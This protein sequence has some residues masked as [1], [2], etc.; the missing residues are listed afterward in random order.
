MIGAAVYQ[1]FIPWD[2]DIDLMMTREEYDRFLE[3][4]PQNCSPRYHLLHYSTGDVTK[5]PAL[6]ARVEDLWT[7][8]EEE[9]ARRVRQGR[10]FVDITVF[11]EVP[12]R[13]RLRLLRLY[14]GYTC[15]FLYRM[16]GMIPGT[17]WKRMLMGLLPGKV[18]EK[19]LRERYLRFEKTCRNAGKDCRLCAELLSAAYGDI[20]YDRRIFEAYTDILFE[21]EKLMIV[22]KYR[23]Y[24]FMRYHRTDFPKELPEERRQKSHILSMKIVHD[25]EE[26]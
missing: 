16:N 6:F 14:A 10:V 21:G 7:Q 24:L 13:I 9:I 25:S 18:S 12:S 19:R 15:T 1:G 11:D 23:D 5:V 17:G 3:V 22:E 20:L 26:E 2:D 4:Y 8:T